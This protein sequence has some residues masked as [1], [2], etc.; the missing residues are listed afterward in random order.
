[1]PYTMFSPS[2]F[3]TLQNLYTQIP[4]P[5]NGTTENAGVGNAV[6]ELHGKPLVF[7]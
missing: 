7:T 2:D 4:I 5:Q 1:M 3:Y 6:I